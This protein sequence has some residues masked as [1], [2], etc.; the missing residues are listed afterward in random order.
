LQLAGRALGTANITVRATNPY[1]GYT[2]RN[3]LEIE[4]I[5][6]PIAVTNT[7]LPRA[8]WNPLYEQMVTVRNTSGFDA[9]GVQLLFT[10]LMPGISVINKTGTN[11]DGRPMILKEGL[12][13]NGST[14]SL[15]V[16]YSCSG[17][18]QVNLYPPRIDALYLPFPKPIP[19][20]D[21]A[22]QI[23]GT[24][25]QDQS[26]RFIL[27]TESV[28]GGLYLV[29]YMN[30]FPAGGWLQIPHPIKASSSRTQW[31]DP[32]PPTTLPVSG[33]RVYRILELSE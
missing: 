15:S 33:V 21:E 23:N 12:F 4:V 24:F 28:I 14:Q 17:A 19:Q 1:T 6:L 2:C 3:N 32:G 22:P 8:P 29:E 18:Y 27:E 11:W 30:N 25:M 16:V 26:G 7:F 13:P 10:N 20:L 31:I 9:S 5:E